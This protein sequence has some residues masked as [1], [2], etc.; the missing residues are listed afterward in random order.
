[1][2]EW[3]QCS[4]TCDGGTAFQLRRCNHVAG[5]TGSTLRYRICNMQPCP[6]AVDFRDHQCSL[7]NEIPYK[8]DLYSWSAHYGGSEADDCRLV[9]RSNTGLVATL[10]SAVQDGTRCSPG[11][12]RL[13]VDGKCQKVGC[14]LVIGSDAKVDGCGVCGG[15]GSTCLQPLYH[16]VVESASLCSATCG[17]G[18][19]MSQVVCRNVMTGINVDPQ[20]CDASQQP[21]SQM[22]ECN[23]HTC[24]AKWVAESWS[25]CSVSCGGGTRSRLVICMRQVNSTFTKVPEHQCKGP[26]LREFEPCNNMPCPPTWVVGPWSG[27]SVSCGE[28]SQT[29]NVSCKLSEFSEPSSSSCDESQKPDTTQPCTTGIPCEIEDTIRILHPYPPFRPVAERLIGEQIVSSSLPSSEPFYKPEAWGAC[30]VT[31]GEGYRKRE[32]PCKIFLEFSRAYARLSDSYCQGT[33]PPTVERCVEA[34]CH[35][36][37]RMETVRDGYGDA[38]YA[39]TYRSQYSEGAIRVAPH[40]TGKTYTWKTQGYTHCSASCLGGVQESLIMC[41]QEDDQK[42]V[43][44]FLC[45]SETRPEALTRTCNDHPCPP[46]WN[47]SE[48]QPCSKP[49]GIGIQTRE[50]NCIHEVTRGEGNKVVVPNH[51]CPQ[52]PPADRQH[53]NI[54]DCPVN[55]HTSVWSKCSK[56]CGGGVK[57]RTVE[58]KQVMAQ[59]HIVSRPVSQCPKTRPPD[60]RPCNTKPCPS[61]DPRPPIIAANQSYVQN[62]PAKRKLG[63]KIGGTAR[64]YHG[65]QIKIKCPVKKFD[66]SK[67][68]WAKDHK[69]ITS[70]KKY[71]I[72]KKGALRIQEVSYGDTGVYTCLAGRSSADITINVKSRP[73]EFPSSEEIERQPNNNLNPEMHNNGEPPQRPFILPGDDESHEQHPSEM[74]PPRRPRPTPPHEIKPQQDTHSTTNSHIDQAELGSTS[75]DPLHYDPPTSGGSRTMPHFHQ[76]ISNLQN[77]WLLQSFANSRGHRMVMEEALEQEAMSSQEEDVSTTEDP[78]GKIV[79]LG[80]G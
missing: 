68:Q 20:L 74:I 36:G 13:C 35:L 2:S 19:R 43:S 33:K 3:S 71:K 40:R 9:C 26:K 73:G 55:W 41:V 70:S 15:D 80:K 16:W 47:H 79:I 18:Y 64:V 52:P 11:S 76:L 39:D 56:R 7:Y 14:D 1:W 61:E 59:N 66:R 34:P 6:D 67:I 28:G 49:C 53:C 69:L 72:S 57:T 30:S 5:C 54:L 75:E 58:C 25:R 10:A 65:T 78:Q 22:I 27:C 42:V 63:L 44:P 37:N 23:T 51:M 32:V 17:T 48:F 38:T 31:C 12:L 60:R 46:R 4:R 45:S 77:A 62:N 21:E 8:G 29:R 50:V 24:P